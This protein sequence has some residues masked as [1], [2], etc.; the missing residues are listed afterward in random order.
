[1]KKKNGGWNHAIIELYCARK[2]SSKKDKYMYEMV[3]NKKGKLTDSFKKIP[4]KEYDPKYKTPKKPSFCPGETPEYLCLEKDC[5]HLA[6]C[7]ADKN[8]Y[9]T[10]YKYLFKRYAN[11]QNT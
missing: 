10:F 6:Y 1:M 11:E 2:W 3:F 9:K 7:N 4:N 8:D 5:P